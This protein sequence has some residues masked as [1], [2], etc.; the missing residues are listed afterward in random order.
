MPLPFYPTHPAMC[1]IEIAESEE[2]LVPAEKHTE[3]FR[4]SSRQKS[5]LVEFFVRKLFTGRTP[6]VALETVPT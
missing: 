5:K 1:L 3:T 6:K 2:S 4:P